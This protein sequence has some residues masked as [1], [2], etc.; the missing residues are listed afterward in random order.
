MVSGGKP[1]FEEDSD[2]LAVD[3]IDGEGHHG[4][5]GERE[6]DRGCGIECLRSLG[7]WGCMCSSAR[8]SLSTS[9]CYNSPPGVPHMQSFLAGSWASEK[10]RHFII[11]WPWIP[12]FALL[13]FS[14][15]RQNISPA[16]HRKRSSDTILVDQVSDLPFG[17]A[18][19]PCRGALVAL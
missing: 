6:G 7:I 17:D 3:G 19:K 10:M 8:S 14:L 2:P 18:Q 16:P 1:L 13:H 9:P 11:S 15:S 5:A 4:F 12:Q